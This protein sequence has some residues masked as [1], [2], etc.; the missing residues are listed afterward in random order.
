MAASRSDSA[1]AIFDAALARPTSEREAFIDAA[2][3]DD[4]ALRE[5]V[6]SLL[7]AHEDAG[8]FLST[9]HLQ[10]PMASPTPVPT[11]TPGMRLGAFEIEALIGAGGMGEVYPRSR[12]AAGSHGRVEGAAGA[13][14]RGSAA[15]SA[16]RARG[17]RHL[18]AHPRPYL[19]A[20]RY[21][22]TGRRRLPGHG[23]RPRRDPVGEACGRCHPGRAGPF[24]PH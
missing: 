12:Y 23:V 13:R 15:A 22:P 21:W 1:F 16:I 10:Q 4:R 2:C 24:L 9:R 14:G 20:S 17:A 8:D 11:L 19:Y 5:E 6:E 7:A 3:R 18:G